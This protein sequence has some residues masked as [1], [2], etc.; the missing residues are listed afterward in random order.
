MKLV[1]FLF[2][3]TAISVGQLRPVQWQPISVPTTASLRGL[4]VVDDNTVWASGTDGTVIR[5]TDSG[6][7]WSVL[8]VP[9]AE[10]LD[11]RG[12]RAFDASTAVIMSSGP[13]EQGQARV[14]RTTDAG[15]HWMLV[16]EEKATGAFFDA[17]AFWDAKH[18]ILV[19]DPV[20]GHFKLFTTEDGG[21]TWQRVPPGK[22]PPALEKEGAFAAS[23]SCLTVQGDNNVWFATGGASVARVFRSTDRGQSWAAVG[24]PLHPA[25]A[26]TGIFSLAFRDAKHGVAV[27]GDY[28]HPTASPAPNILTTEDGGKTWQP[29]AP[30]EPPGLFFSGVVYTSP[31]S[32]TT[33]W[34]VG[35]NGVNFMTPDGK[36]HKKS[37]D[38]FNAIAFSS[39]GVG[40][41]VGPKGAVTRW[42]TDGN[43]EKPYGVSKQTQALH[44][45]IAGTV[46]VKN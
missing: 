28:A 13:A 16:L 39:S 3:M 30:S 26:S 18:G 22:L 14:S 7:T 29:A 25:N 1:L 19:G 42:S 34:A 32:G 43:Q 23:N 38:N 8:A 10:K 12:I 40:W 33:I 27:G 21:V 24:T 9:Q 11:F 6:K 20:D 36:W 4:S 15:K 2:F 37:D 45:M 17:I 41:A 44:D 31:A 5:T 46:V 35:S